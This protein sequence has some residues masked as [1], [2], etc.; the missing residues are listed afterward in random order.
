MRPC[1]FVFVSSLTLFLSHARAEEICD[2]PRT[3]ACQATFTGASK[4]ASAPFE[5]ENWDEPSLANCAATAYFVALGGSEAVENTTI[6][7]RAENAGELNAAAIQ[8]LVSAKNGMKY[9][10]ADYS[11]GQF[12]QGSD[13]RFYLDRLPLPHTVLVGGNLVHEISLE[14]SVE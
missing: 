2:T 7:V 6:R 14:C 4:K 9:R 8:T 10:H 11:H 3:L 12:R 5:N 13:G 1:L